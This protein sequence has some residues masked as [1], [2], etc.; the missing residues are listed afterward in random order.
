L[1]GR[2]S[3]D[4]KSGLAVMIHAAAAARDEGLLETGCIGIVLVPDEETAGPKGSR[5]LDA[6]GLLGRDGVGMLTP[7][8]TGGVIWN[9]NR[10]AILLRATMRGNQH[11]LVGDSKVSTRSNS[12]C[13][14][15]R[16]F[17]TSKKK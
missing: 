13:P 6:R 2:G 3:S 7:E 10:G 5:N 8:P 1:F 12:R 16:D 14:Q 4:M 11:T 17:S 9:A 15:W